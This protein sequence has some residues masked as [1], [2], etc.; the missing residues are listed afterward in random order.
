MLL[1]ELMYFFISA[2]T[3]FVVSAGEFAADARDGTAAI[4]AVEI[5]AVSKTFRR[6][7]ELSI[8]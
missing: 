1:A 3:I 6:E 2:V 8:S 7:I 5:A 4:A